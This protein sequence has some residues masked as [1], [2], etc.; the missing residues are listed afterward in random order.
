M[1]TPAR[2]APDGRR[3][4]RSRGRGRGDQPP[5]VRG[6]APGKLTLLALALARVQRFDS[7]ELTLVALSAADFDQAGAR[8]ATQRGSSTNCAR[9]RA[10]R[11]PARPRA[12]I[13]RAQGPAQSL[14]ARH[15]RRR[16][17]I[18]HR[19]GAGRRRSPARSRLLYH[20]R[21]GGAGRVPA[22][23]IAEQLH[24]RP[25]GRA[26]VRRSPDALA[27]SAPMDG[28]LLIDKPAGMT[29]HDVVAR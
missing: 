1:R 20:A 21:R 9:C 22:R 5:A 18:G 25:D 12:L 11:S 24:A 8:T 7:G 15:R 4:D 3:A 26:P 6:H 13:R 19:S 10:R 28:I 2:G 27:L 14:A 16:R 17:R 23:A 29:S